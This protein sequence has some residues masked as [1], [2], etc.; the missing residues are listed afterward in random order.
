LSAAA[1][2]VRV[3]RTQDLDRL[4]ELFFLLLEEHQAH[5]P[6]FEPGPEAREGRRSLLESRLRMPE[7]HVLVAERPAGEAASQLLGFCVAG[8]ARRPPVF[9]ERLRGEIEY[10][11]VR[12]EARRGGVGSTLVRHALAWLAQQGTARVALQVARRNRAGLAF[13]QALRFQPVMDV[14]ERAL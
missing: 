5:D 2:A 7:A 8:L 14:L 11:F 6:A 10:L 12:D 13:W 9:R 1:V 3:A 4:V